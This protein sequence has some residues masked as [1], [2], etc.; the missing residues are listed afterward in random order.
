MNKPILI[1][2]KDQAAFVALARQAVDHL[3]ELNPN[4]ATIH[5][6][7]YSTGDVIYGLICLL[8]R[9]DPEHFT[10]ETNLYQWTRR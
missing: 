6:S 5:G 4:D 9:N 7:G 8:E 1:S 3:R 2:Q 10:N